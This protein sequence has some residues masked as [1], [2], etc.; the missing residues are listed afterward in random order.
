MKLGKLMF[1]KKWT[2][3][4]NATYLSVFPTENISND[5]AITYRV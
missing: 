4:T 3:T 5:A 2:A 1:K